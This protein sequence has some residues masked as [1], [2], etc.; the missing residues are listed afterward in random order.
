MEAIHSHPFYEFAILL[1]ISAILA[2]LGKILKQPIIISFIAV[3]ILIGPEV[4]DL[5]QSR[6]QIELLAEIGIAI[7][8]FIVGLK[9]DLNLIK[10]TGPVA[11]ITGIGQIIFTAGFGYLIAISLNFSVVHSIYIAVALTF[12]STIIIVKMLS[13]KNE[14]DKLHGQ[15]AMGFLIVQD[16]AV[17]I[18][19]IVLSAFGET[20]GETNI[21]SQLLMVLLKGIAFIAII[22]LLIKYVI[23]SALRKLARNKELLVLSSIAWA[24]TLAAAGDYLGFGLEVGA[25]VAGMSLASTHYREIIS[26]RLESIRDFMLL[27]F[28]INLG[29][30]IELSILGDQL[31]PAILF[32]LFVLIGNPIIVMVIMGIMGYKKRVSFLAGLTVAQISEFSLILAALGL[33]NGHIDEETLGL[34]TLVGLITIGLSTYIILYSGPIFQKLSPLL[35]IFEKKEPTKGK[36]D[37]TPETID[38]IIIGVGSFGQHL[39]ENLLENN[40]NI[41]IVDFDPEVVNH[42]L[43]KGIKAEYA[44]AQD[45]ELP[46]LLPI[47]NTNHIIS[48]STNVETN[49]RLL[50]FMEENNFEGKITTLAQSDNDEEKLKECGSYTVL[51]PFKEAATKILENS[52]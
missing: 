39:A 23:D 40:H 2:S 48:T 15:I 38:Y 5:L 7:L 11:F 4:L 6:E 46:S 37:E 41:M 9:L 35:S 19:M 20:G 17:V 16:I 49:I 8:L 36:E 45:P 24:V 12:S 1:L 26:G 31:I 3:G 47:K 18:T 21:G 43:D 13:D 34:I 14:I 25:F 42:W 28:F 44:D 29:A 22:I 30:D 52:N 10:S 33:S 51:R 50:K 32:S 27:F